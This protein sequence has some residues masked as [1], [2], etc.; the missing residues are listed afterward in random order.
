MTELTKPDRWHSPAA[1]GRRAVSTPGRSWT[2]VLDAVRKPVNDSRML[3][4]SCA[5]TPGAREPH[6]PCLSYMVSWAPAHRTK[7]G[8]SQPRVEAVISAPIARRP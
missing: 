2:A 6:T 3:V 5:I 7:R 4:P 1:A 8:G